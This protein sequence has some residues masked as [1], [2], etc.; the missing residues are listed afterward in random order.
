[1]A[2]I[3]FLALVVLTNCCVSIADTCCQI[4]CRTSI[5]VQP[6][7]EN[8][9]STSTGVLSSRFNGR[10]PAG[11][12]LY[13]CKHVRVPGADQRTSAFTCVYVLPA[14]VHSD[15]RLLYPSSSSRIYKPTVRRSRRAML[16]S[17][18]LL[19]ANVEPNPGPSAP[20][21]PRPCNFGLFN[22]RSAR[23][24]AAVIHDVMAS[25]HLDVAALT[26][27]WIPS[28]APDAVKLDIAPSGYR[29]IHVARGTT[30]EKGGG[31]VAFIY[32]ESIRL[33]VINIGQY[34]TFE[35]VAV[36]IVEQASSTIIVCIYRTPGSV[37]NVFCSDLSDLFDELLVL[38]SRFLVCGDLNCPGAD[39][40]MDT[41]LADLLSCHNLIQ[42]VRGS[43]HEKG[44]LL[45]LL[46][47]RESDMNL[48]NNICLQSLCFTDHS[49][50]G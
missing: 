39:Q 44:N 36:K 47:T 21:V 25:N 28:D 38:G 17:I 27:T 7:A 46:I 37:T 35:H 43:T 20:G 41:H 16:T 18:L 11:K 50:V 31:G 3:L 45:D 48:V 1:M 23:N 14:S 40:Q 49:L 30:A 12:L 8:G 2:V 19:L 26:E 42:H 22:A 15:R 5:I 9:N 13:T 24:K 10:R 34:G 6:P 32:R 4:T 29:V 33:S